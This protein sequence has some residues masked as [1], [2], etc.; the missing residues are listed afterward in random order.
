[1]TWWRG[2]LRSRIWGGREESKGVCHL[3]V[4]CWTSL[5]NEFCYKLKGWKPVLVYNNIVRQV[6]LPNRTSNN[7]LLRLQ[8]AWTGTTRTGLLQDHLDQDDWDP[9]SPFVNLGRRLSY[10]KISHAGLPPSLLHTALGIRLTGQWPGNEANWTV[11]WEW[12]WMDSDLGMRLT[13]NWPGNET[14]WKLAWE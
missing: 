4:G 12:D 2:T 3:R 6:L 11:A 14:Y 8:F 7:F 5:E 9:L 10:D 13:G 1:M